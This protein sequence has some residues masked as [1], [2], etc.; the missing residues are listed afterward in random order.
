MPSEPTTM[1]DAANDTAG[2]Y[3]SVFGYGHVPSA[4]QAIGQ[5]SNEPAQLPAAIDLA[6]RYELSDPDMLLHELNCLADEWQCC[7][8][9]FQVGD[10][11]RLEA[12]RRRVH[13]LAGKLLSTL[14]EDD[15]LLDLL[16]RRIRAVDGIDY[17]LNPDR[18]CNMLRALHEASQHALDNSS[19]PMPASSRVDAD[20][21]RRWLVVQLAHLYERQTAQRASA[22]VDDGQPTGNAGSRFIA[23]AFLK[24]TGRGIP[25][26]ALVRFVPKQ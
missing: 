8:V 12:G 1:P 14:Q 26:S 10:R 15:I 13:R 17:L 21:R 5:P 6:K 22:Y 25:N 7:E 16:Q 19:R 9:M 4:G 23:E 11:K 2:V 18:L 3:R 24:L 20:D